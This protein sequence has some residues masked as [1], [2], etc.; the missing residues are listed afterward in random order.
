M[1]CMGR[2]NQWGA[3]GEKEGGTQSLVFHGNAADRVE[4]KKKI[5]SICSLTVVSQ[6]EL[7]NFDSL[8]MFS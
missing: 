4:K 8:V 3:Q 1:M 5:E 7:S 6:T 2:E